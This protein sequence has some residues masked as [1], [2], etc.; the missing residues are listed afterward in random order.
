MELPQLLPSGV[1]ETLEAKT[2]KL[3]EELKDPTDFVRSC[4]LRGPSYL[5]RCIDE[6]GN[7]ISHI[8][9]K[10]YMNLS[11][12]GYL[13]SIY[14]LCDDINILKFSTSEIM[15]LI[16]SIKMSSSFI[17]NFLVEPYDNIQ[18]NIFLLDRLL[19][20]QDLCNRSIEFTLSIVRLKQLV[21][22]FIP[23]NTIDISDLDSENS[24]NCCK[25]PPID[26]ARASAMI[27]ELES[28]LMDNSKE[29]DSYANKLKCGRNRISLEFLE[30][31]QE[32]ISWLRKTSALYRQQGHK[33]LIQGMQIS[34]K[35][36]IRLGSIVLHNFG[37]LW[38]HI[39]TIVNDVLLRQVHHTFQLSALKNC[40]NI[41]AKPE[42]ITPI[43][44]SVAVK[45]LLGTINRTLNVIVAGLQQLLR[46]YE[47]LLNNKY[48]E[49]PA[50]G[51]FLLDRDNLNFVEEYWFKCS[52]ILSS[53]FKSLN[54]PSIMLNEMIEEPEAEI[55]F[56]GHL[57]SE[58][59]LQILVRFYPDISRLLQTTCKYIKRRLLFSLQI[60]SSDISS[61][62]FSL[63]VAC[64]I[65][66][67]YINCT[68]L[69]FVKLFDSLLNQKNQHYIPSQ[70]TKDIHILI[71]SMIEV[72][73]EVKDTE[74]V[75]S[76][77]CEI[78]RNL[79]L[80]FIVTCGTI[81]QPEGSNIEF[82][83]CESLTEDQKNLLPKKSG[84][85]GF[86]FSLKKPLPK[87]NN[88]HILNGYIATV[89]G[90]L[91]AELEK[92]FKID[93][94]SSINFT[95]KSHLVDLLRSLQYKATARWFVNLAR[96]IQFCL[97]PL[98]H[99][100]TLN[101]SGNYY[102]D[103]TFKIKSNSNYNSSENIIYISHYITKIRDLISHVTDKWFTLLS[104]IRLWHKCLLAFCRYVTLSFLSN[105]ALLIDIDET[106]CHY[107]AGNIA[108]LQVIMSQV[109]EDGVTSNLLQKEIYML[110]DFRRVV[111]SDIFTIESTLINQTNFSDD[112][113]LLFQS[114]TRLP[115]IL[116]SL[117]LLFRL[118]VGGAMETIYKDIPCTFSKY[119]GISTEHLA[120]I[121]FDT[122]FSELQFTV[123]NGSDKDLLDLFS[124][125]KHVVSDSEYNDIRNSADLLK[126]I[127]E[128]VS[129]LDQHSSLY[130]NVT[131]RGNNI[132]YLVR[133]TVACI[134]YLVNRK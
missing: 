91:S 131:E 67:E 83:I 59:V 18:F 89:S 6:F 75:C 132:I 11:S 57:S 26:L 42:V 98:M 32:D 12:L 78:F 20:V 110:Y 70:I 56:V 88:S 117:Q 14:A 105:S 58:Q 23:L 40:I 30:F 127:S 39:D 24:K 68:R 73:S 2:S 62:I 103:E 37:E 90:T 55:P 85:T 106:K 48:Q 33:M 119:L 111:F 96:T 129:L 49:F 93:T 115:I 134:N 50:R 112:N 126:K 118:P 79:I 8:D 36:L 34:D 99:Q 94:V 3:V 16:L 15:S 64:N 44:I 69:R 74:D 47:V 29:L 84:Y 13:R 121:V 28:M 53:V 81:V 123:E 95:D 41:E 120:S 77:V 25:V 107:I 9:E 43:K 80:H 65:R 72:F 100:E 35:N 86:Q 128:Y 17:T 116:S 125:R 82:Y 71:K 60:S 54:N 31:L 109:L 97:L 38:D 66:E 114:I 92:M 52:S 10:L 21:N 61:D 63:N 101:T 87:P 46:L 104:P 27:V 19:Q 4:V 5:S 113:E 45:L 51:G 122:I 108:E 124:Y 76:T 22:P 102:K 1:S 133:S 130:T 7:V